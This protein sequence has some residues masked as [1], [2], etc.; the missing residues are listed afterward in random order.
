MKAYIKVHIYADLMNQ[1]IEQT[2]HNYWHP[3]T[4]A[5]ETGLYKSEYCAYQLLECRELEWEGEFDFVSGKIKVLELKLGDLQV[6]SNNIKE[7]IQELLCIGHDNDVKS[8]AH[9]IPDPIEFHDPSFDW[10]MGD[11]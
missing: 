11:E 10:P 7:Q 5:H 4:T 6:Q 3:G 8:P 2:H 9:G 1:R